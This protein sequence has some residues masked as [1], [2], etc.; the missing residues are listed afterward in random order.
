MSTIEER[1]R[2]IPKVE[3]HEHVDGSIPAEVTWDL[4]RV[5]G[6]HPV[7]SL[8]D[9]RRLLEI[10]EGEEGSLLAYLDKMHYP[11]WVTQ[12][13]ENIVRVT[14]AIVDAAWDAGVRTLEL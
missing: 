14:E 3:L 11:L 8:D 13:Y 10:R 7:E 12:F 4:M 6:L 1:V 9:M 2:G 5:Y